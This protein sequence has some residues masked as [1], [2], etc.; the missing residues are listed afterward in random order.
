MPPVGES[1]PQYSRVMAPTLAE[2]VVGDPPES[3]KAAGF[4]VDDDDTV[5]IGSIRVVLAGRSDG[6]RIRGWSFTDVGPDVHDIDGLPTAPTAF[7]PASGADHPNGCVSIDHVVVLT[8]DLDRTL[9]AFEHLGLTARSTRESDTYGV[10]MRQAFIRSG[11]AILEIVGPV[12][13]SDDDGPAGFFGLA[14]TV[15]DLDDTAALLGDRL[16]RIKTAVQPGRRI[17]TLRHRDVDMSVATA[18]MT[19]EP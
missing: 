8:P 1:A 16:G 9:G 10:P 19:A 6:K 15:A 13:P 5:R 14:H 3:W 12:E 2:I 4:S 7:G 17:A 18:F 11:E